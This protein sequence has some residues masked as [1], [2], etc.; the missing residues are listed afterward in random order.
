MDKENSQNPIATIDI[1]N[2]NG[3]GDT[4]KNLEKQVN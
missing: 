2:C 1:K 4:Y 3:K